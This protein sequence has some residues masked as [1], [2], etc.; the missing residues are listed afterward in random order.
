MSSADFS[1]A[2]DRRATGLA[3]WPG[4]ARTGVLTT[5]HGSIETPAFIFCATKAA[6]KGATAEQVAACNSQI[7]LSNT[8]HLMLQPGADLVAKMGG[9]HRFTGWSGPMLTDS[10]GYQ[11]FAMGHGS[12]SQEVKGSRND[13]RTPTLLEISE[14][15]AVFKSYID[16]SRHLLTP[17]LSIETQVKLGADLIVVFDECTAFHDDR[18]YT[19]RS[20][21]LSHRWADRCIAEFDRLGGLEKQRL[22]GV[23]QGGVYQDLRDESVAFNNSR[24]VFG[25]AVGGCLG[26][27]KA[28]MVEVVGYAMRELGGDRPVHLLGIGGIADIWQGICRGVDTFDCVGPTRVARHGAAL[29]RPALAEAEGGKP[30]SD[31]INLRNAK[32]REDKRPLDPE[33]DCG[34]T[35]NHSRAYIHHLLRADEMVGRTLLT[36]HNISFMNRL[37][38]DVRAA[39]RADRIAEAAKWWLGEP[40]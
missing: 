39:I 32:F 20:M 3:D 12:V 2:V 8:Y 37:M 19:A 26:G 1:F 4:R 17:E 27:D 23:V 36:L 6:M 15:G 29:I 16:G 34:L 28:D 22:Y 14:K 35:R 7:I 5:P 33:S 24:D 9:L 38:R 10:G 40:I 11:V 30:G 31:R 21:A 13:N 18:D 25:I